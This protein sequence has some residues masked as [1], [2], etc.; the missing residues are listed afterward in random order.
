MEYKHGGLS[1]G[2]RASSFPDQTIG[3]FFY[4]SR[5]LYLSYHFF[6]KLKIGQMQAVSVIWY[7]SAKKSVMLFTKRC[8]RRRTLLGNLLMTSDGCW[9]ESR[10]DPDT[11]VGGGAGRCKR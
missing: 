2:S 3:Y 7:K 5:L 11:S 10:P 8:A 6:W 9:G 4:R 1:K